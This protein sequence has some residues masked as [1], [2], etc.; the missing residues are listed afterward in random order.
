[1]PNIGPL[2]IAIV[3]VVAVIIFG[4]KRLPEL[5]QG[6]GRGMREFKAGI[7]GARMPILLRSKRDLTGRQIQ[8]LVRIKIPVWRSS[9]RKTS[10]RV[11][12]MRF[13]SGARHARFPIRS[14]T[15]WPGGG[16]G[17]WLTAPEHAEW[18]WFGAPD[19]AWRSEAGTE[20]WLLY[21]RETG[22]QLAYVETAMS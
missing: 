12:P 6:L 11:S 14:A 9:Q 5:G 20:G 4:P 19:H 1:M 8:T 3:V 10:R 2:E 22:E 7:A 18:I 16:I 15:C 17:R 21:D 13:S